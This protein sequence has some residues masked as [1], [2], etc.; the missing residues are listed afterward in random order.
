MHLLKTNPD[1]ENTK[2]KKSPPSK[3][4]FLFAFS[5]RQSDPKMRAGIASS[6]DDVVA[7]IERYRSMHR[8]VELI[9]VYEADFNKKI[10]D[11]IE[12]LL[13]SAREVNS[14]LALQPTDAIYAI[15]AEGPFYAS[16]ALA[17]SL[18]AP[19]QK[20]GNTNTELNKI[21]NAKADRLT[22]EMI[23]IPVGATLIFNNALISPPVNLNITAVVLD[24]K[25]KVMCSTISDDE[26][27]LAISRAAVSLFNTLTGSKRT[28]LQGSLYWK[29]K[30]PDPRIGIETLQVRR[31]RLH[32]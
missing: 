24:N 25:N 5:F 32:K 27:H 9:E 10:G 17:S 21:R 18:G 4:V 29:Y 8:D 11:Y 20:F 12:D 22:F 6:I 2:A 1:M 23:G 15:D 3:K 19:V 31:E 28:S 7:E 16:V 13:S 14:T 26:K 30:D